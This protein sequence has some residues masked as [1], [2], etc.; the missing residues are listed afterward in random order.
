MEKLIEFIKGHGID[1]RIGVNGKIEAL[2]IF[3]DGSASWETI[4]PRLTAVRDWLG[5]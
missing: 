1:A 3:S 4:D 5:Y 2:A